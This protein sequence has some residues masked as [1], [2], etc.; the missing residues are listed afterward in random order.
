MY[1]TGFY[2]LKSVRRK[3]RTVFWSGNVK[4]D[5]L[6]GNLS[7]PVKRITRNMGK[8]RRRMTD[9][10]HTVYV[11]VRHNFEHFCDLVDR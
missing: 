11:L 9:V 5:C 4:I 8:S 7:L 2:L 1:G 10:Y 6:S 3:S